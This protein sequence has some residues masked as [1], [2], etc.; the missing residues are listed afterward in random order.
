MYFHEPSSYNMRQRF[1]RL[2]IIIYFICDTNKCN[3]DIYKYNSIS[4]LHASAS[5]KPPQG[6]PYQSLTPTKKQQIIKIIHIILQYACNISIMTLKHVAV[7][8]IYICMYQGCIC[9]C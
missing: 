4:L 5:F 6:A 2:Y 1:S 7:I 9:W 3:L 8:Q